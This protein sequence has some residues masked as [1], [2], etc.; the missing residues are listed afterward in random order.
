[1]SFAFLQSYVLIS[2]LM[3]SLYIKVVNMLLIWKH[4]PFLPFCILLRQ[5]FSILCSQMS[6]F[7]FEDSC[8]VSVLKVTFLLPDEVNLHFFIAVS[9]SFG[10]LKT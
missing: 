2:I 10:W 8:M 1:M 3:K 5:E 9:F 4:Y 7:S 6:N